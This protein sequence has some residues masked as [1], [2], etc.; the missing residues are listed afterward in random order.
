MKRRVT[1]SFL[2]FALLLV[3]FNVT[4]I[5]FIFNKQF[6]LALS[7]ILFAFSNLLIIEGFVASF[8]ALKSEKLGHRIYS[9]PI[10]IK[11]FSAVSFQVLAS[12]ICFIINSFFD[13]KTFIALIISII[14]FIAFHA[15][16]I[17]NFA[18]KESIVAV[19]TKEES[20][21]DIF[22]KEMKNKSSGLFIRYKEKLG[23]EKLKSLKEAFAYATPFTTEDNADV[24]NRI[25]DS[26]NSLETS[27]M[28]GDFTYSL[29][30]I[31]EILILLKE[32]ENISL[33]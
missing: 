32:R 27:L 26:M 23:V 4:F 10:L 33:K 17:I 29:E 5:C 13:L 31:D 1:I 22:I 9:I 19:E 8:F 25:S 21:N 28:E 18:H 30:I 20:F 11:V 7:W 3:A 14:T 16:L 15:F 2:L 24:E 6:N 12:I